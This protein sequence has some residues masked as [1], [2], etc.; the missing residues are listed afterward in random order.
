VGGIKSLLKKAAKGAVKAAAGFAV[1][2][3]LGAAASLLPI[4]KSQAAQPFNQPGIQ[5]PGGISFDLPFSGRP[6]AG[7]MRTGGAGR[8]QPVE[9]QCPK[10]FHLNKHKS[11]DGLPARSFCTRNRRVNFANGRAAGRAGRRLRGTVKML[12]RSFTLVTAKPPKG[13]F[14]VR[15]KGR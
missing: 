10:G 11:H 1:G 6:G 13:K 3:P 5:L 14:I 7:F 8:V 12:K 2:G 9:G 15:K 4:K